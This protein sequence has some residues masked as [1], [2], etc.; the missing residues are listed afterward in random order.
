MPPIWKSSKRFSPKRTSQK[1]GCAGV[2]RDRSYIRRKL[3][4][5]SCTQH[6]LSWDSSQCI[7]V[8]FCSSGTACTAASTEDTAHRASRNSPFSGMCFKGVLHRW[9]H[10][11]QE[12]PQS[13]AVHW[14]RVND[15]K[16]CT[17]GIV[18]LPLDYVL[19]PSRLFWNDSILYVDGFGWISP[20]P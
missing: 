11:T 10:H 15:V 9:Q 3:K 6:L 14:G 20:T 18:W 7:T 1:S 8:L 5:H 19:D 2:Q 4:W 17:I 12:P 16:K 13:T